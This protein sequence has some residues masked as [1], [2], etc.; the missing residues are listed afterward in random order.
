MAVD[1]AEWVYEHPDDP[2][3]ITV[4]HD[5]DGIHIAVEAHVLPGGD[6]SAVEAECRRRGAELKAALEAALLGVKG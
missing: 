1:P 3:R 6:T 2:Y 5:E 4:R